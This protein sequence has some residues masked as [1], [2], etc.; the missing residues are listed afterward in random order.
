[1]FKSFNRSLKNRYPIL[2]L[3]FENMNLKYNKL[4]IYKLDNYENDAYD[5]CIK[6][7]LDY[8]SMQ[9]INN[10]I[11]NMIIKGQNSKKFH[12]LEY[13]NNLKSTKLQMYNKTNII[14]NNENID[15]NIYNNNINNNDINCTFSYN[16]LGNYNIYKPY[17]SLIT[18]KSINLVEIEKNRHKNSKNKSE[19]E[20]NYQINNSNNKKD[21]FQSFKY[22]LGQKNENN[23]NIN[24]LN[25]LKDNIKTL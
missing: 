19:I 12:N 24:D 2:V 5:F 20:N 25:Y 13:N 15:H 9:E 23:L 1:M 8:K 6:N 22:L 10:I 16:R 18:N 14:K 7:E 3:S 11:K 21:A 17:S 4:S